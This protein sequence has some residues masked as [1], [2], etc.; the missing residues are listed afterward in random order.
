[1][2]TMKTLPLFVAASLQLVCLALGT[3]GCTTFKC[4]DNPTTGADGECISWARVG[5]GNPDCNTGADEDAGKVSF[6]PRQ[7][8]VTSAPAF[9]IHSCARSLLT[10]SKDD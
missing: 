2:P 5:D 9:G 10:M 4:P 3:D 8:R 1:M 7:V 6:C